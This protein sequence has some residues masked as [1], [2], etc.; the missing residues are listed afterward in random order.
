MFGR[1]KSFSTGIFASEL[2]MVRGELAFPE[3]FRPPLFFPPSIF[4]LAD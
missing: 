4:L 2:P 1:E 3:V